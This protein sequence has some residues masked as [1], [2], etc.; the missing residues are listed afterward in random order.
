MRRT[1]IVCTLGPASSSVAM[2][3]KLLDTG[4]NVARLNFSHGTHDQHAV[5]IAAARQAAAENQQDLALLLDTKGPEIRIGTFA[6][7]KVRL[8]EGQVFTLTTAEVA[9]T[10]KMVSVNY[11]GIVN[12]VE[13]GMKILLDDGL[14]VMEAEEVTETEV[15]CRVITGGDLSDRKGV[16]IPGARL[17]L[18][19]ISEKDREDILFA[20]KS[21]LDFIAASFV[22]KADDVIAIRSILEAHRSTIHIIAKIESQEGVDNIDKILEAAD[23][24]MVAR[25]DLGVE[26]PAEEVPLVQKMIISKC[27]AAGKPVITATQMLDSMI[28]NPRPTRAEASDVANAIFDGTDAVM[29]SGETAVGKY[30][31]E[32]VQTMSRIAERTETA[33]HYARI[34][35][36]FD[37]PAERSVTD[38]ISYATCHAAQELGASAIITATQ[39][40]F[41]ARNVSKYKPKSRIIAVTP[42][43]HVVRKLALTWGVFPVMCRPTTSTDEMFSAAIEASLVSGYIE[44]GDLILITAGVPVGVS[45]STNLL[46]VHTVGDIVLQGTGLG[47]NPVTARARIAATGAEAAKLEEGEILVAPATDSSFVPYL[48]K[49]AG[50]L[51]EEG[52]L[53]SHAAVVALHMGLPVIVGAAGAT[54]RL[55]DGDLLTLDTV[56]GLVYRGKA[57]IF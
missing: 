55:R 19:A 43:K 28:R 11:P 31:L 25:G 26:I 2:L 9:G 46:R 16:N 40:G 47:K 4:M 45:G 37:P 35:E 44:N 18:P 32:T 29:L 15:R 22:R 13:T 36:S 24:I 50:V 6:D 21:D 8:E 51:V 41:T 1:K 49:A 38:A 34:L 52:G 5:T 42:R 30:P 39:S 7:G 33:L 10:D 56:R 57:T 27:N 54:S 23:G 48:E 12:D 20:I 53:T 17:N 3:K 14:I